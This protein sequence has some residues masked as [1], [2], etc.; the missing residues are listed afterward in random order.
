MVLFPNFKWTNWHIEKEPQPT[1]LEGM[2]E[3]FVKSFTMSECNQNRINFIFSIVFILLIVIVVRSSSF[4]KFRRRI[5]K[6]FS[7]KSK[8]GSRFNAK[9]RRKGK[10]L[11]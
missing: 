6:A 11:R 7:K 9:K 1:P 4:R 8:K 2:T 3:R 5:S 10:T